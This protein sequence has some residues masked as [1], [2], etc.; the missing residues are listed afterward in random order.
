M[1]IVTDKTV[2]SRDR[3]KLHITLGVAGAVLVALITSGTVWHEQPSFCG[4]ICHTPMKGYVEGYES[5]DVALL[6]S[7]HAD[8]DVACLDCHEPT[9]QQQLTE[10]SHWV[11]GEYA[12]DSDT[13]K[14]ATRSDELV[15]EETCL[16]SGCHDMT[17]EELA[18]ETAAMQLNPH[19]FGE[20]HANVPCSTCHTVHGVSVQYCTQCH[21]N[22]IPD[23]P[24]G[25]QTV[26][27]AS[28]VE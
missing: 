5:G 8:H 14:L 20:F 7:V 25:W 15:T 2:A 12:Y 28:E 13:R 9:I 21:S 23:V 10:L 4:A 17:L 18:Q 26:A 1:I 19:E 16:Q 6:A 11:S 22:T 24:E 3:K 27:Q